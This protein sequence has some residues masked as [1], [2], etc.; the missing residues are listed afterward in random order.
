MSYKSN[1]KIKVCGMRETENIK[2]VSQLR[3]D[4]MGFIF[5]KDS[6]RFVGDDFKIPVLTDV[7]KVGV[8]VNASVDEMKT[9]Y[10]K[11][12]LD[13][14]QLHGSES[15][16]TCM[17]LK[18]EGICVIKVFS[19]HDDFDFEETKPYSQSVDFFLF[20]TKGKYHGGN[21][22][23]FNWHIL[24]KYN[25]DKSFFL[26]GGLNADNIASIDKIKAMNL[27]AVD[28]NSGVEASAGMK[29]INKIKEIQN[30]LA[31]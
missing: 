25:Q 23:T 21:A 20:D 3:P 13:Y 6:P 10:R 16:G 7:K 14:L 30:I 29:D 4:Y 1:I 24:E 12:K 19:V 2:T 15:P 9:A 27:H 22:K 31:L 8:F 17:K 11:H 28:L 18:A 26:S 5:Y